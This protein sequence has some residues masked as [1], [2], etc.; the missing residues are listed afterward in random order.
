MFVSGAEVTGVGV[1][2]SEASCD[3]DRAKVSIASGVS[4]S[5]DLVTRLLVK[6]IA[7]LSAACLAMSSISSAA[8]CRVSRTS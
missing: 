3:W 8:V 1:T 7:S 2:L 4:A 6:Y 5:L